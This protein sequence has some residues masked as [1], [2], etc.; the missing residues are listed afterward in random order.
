MD[1]VTALVR[2]NYNGQVYA[3]CRERGIHYIGHVLEDEGSHARLGCG[4]GHY[5]RQQY[6]QD[7]AGTDV[8][9]GQILPGRDGAASWYGIANA[10]GEFYHYGLAKLASSEAHINP[11][12]QGRSMCET[13]AM[14]GQQGL[15]EKKFLVDHL[16]VNGVN[17]ILFGELSSYDA[18]TEYAKVL[19]EYTER[20]SAL[21]RA[22]RPVIRTALLYHAQAE[23]MTGQEAQGFQTPAAVLARN[24][25]SYDVI[26]EDVFSEPERYGADFTDGLSVN[27][28]RYEAL[29]IPRTRFLAEET[30][31]FVRR[32]GMEGFPVFFVDELPESLKSAAQGGEG[33]SSFQTVPLGL[34]AEEVRKSIEAD[35]RVEGQGRNWIRCSHIRRGTED[36]FLI[37]NESP[38]GAQRCEI[39][40]PAEKDRKKIVRTDPVSGLEWIPP[41]E[42]LPDGSIR[43]PIGL[44][45][46]ETVLLRYGEESGDIP[47]MTQSGNLSWDVIW[48]LELPDGRH[49]AGEPNEIPRAE[50]FLPRDFYGRLVYRAQW[51]EKQDSVCMDMEVRTDGVSA[52]PAYLCADGVSDCCSA[53]LNGQDLGK[54]VGSV[55]FF[56][57]AGALRPG[58]N[59]LEIEV[60]T[61][62]ANIRSG[63]SIFGIPLDT[64]TAFAYAAVE[65]L[66][67]YG[68]VRRS[69]R[70]IPQKSRI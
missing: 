12:K 9:A 22:S 39:F 17:R 25:I 5:F 27:G 61:S 68:T 65:P 10:D 49:I 16:L 43:L 67:I 64:L 26:P 59:E 42:Q 62:A 2:D 55:C 21:L 38:D 28:N 66:G 36:M 63:K 40:L 30:E 56:D 29:V 15:T 31:A 13:F 20:M 34:L 6:Y 52:A 24:Q 53:V 70:I 51:E 19:A 46:Y 11:L 8:I 33:G 14:Y 4:P 3:F 7:E 54:R 60:Y 32:C 18:P 23:W 57:M 41:Q 58:H 1:A 44:G 37:H 50:D 47:E 69:A 35:I 48:T 45:R